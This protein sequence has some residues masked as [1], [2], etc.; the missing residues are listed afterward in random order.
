VN[1]PALTANFFE[2]EL[3]GHAKG[4][5]TGAVESRIG[6]FEMADGGAIFLE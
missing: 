5:F 1:Y 3:F 4:V 6:R 2:S